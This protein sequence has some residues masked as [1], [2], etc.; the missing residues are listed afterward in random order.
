MT[1]RLD[2]I[3]AILGRLAERQEQTQRQLDQFRGEVRASVQE[4]AA[5]ITE[6]MAS[7]ANDLDALGSQVNAY[8]AQSTANLAVEGLDRAEFRRQMMGCKLRLETFCGSWQICGSSKVTAT[9]AEAISLHG[10]R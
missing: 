3:E 10:Y 2:R 4:A 6:L 1:E 5:D 7:L 9:K 8:I